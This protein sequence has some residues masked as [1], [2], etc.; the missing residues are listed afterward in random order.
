MADD[1]DLHPYEL[2]DSAMMINRRRHVFG[3]KILLTEERG[4]E[5]EPFGAVRPWGV[6]DHDLVDDGRD[7]A[8][9]LASAQGREDLAAKRIAK[10]G[11]KKRRDDGE[12]SPAREDFAGVTANV[13][14]DDP[15]TAQARRERTRGEA[16]TGP[17]RAADNV[18]EAV[19]DGGSRE[20]AQGRRA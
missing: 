18:T 16:R 12:K 5:L 11:G 1:T 6:D 2:L 3:D 14:A 4:D 7:L 19:T 15:I 13:V 9:I 8:G 20:K 17:G 10:R